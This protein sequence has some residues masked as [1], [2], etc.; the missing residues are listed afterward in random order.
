[1]ATIELVVNAADYT[2]NDTSTPLPA[3]AWTVSGNTLVGSNIEIPTSVYD[4]GPARLVFNTAPTG[5]VFYRDPPA[6][7]QFMQKTDGHLVFVAAITASSAALD[8]AGVYHLVEAAGYS[9]SILTAPAVAISGGLSVAAA[10][11]DSFFS[12][13]AANYP[14]GY[15]LVPWHMPS[16]TPL[17]SFLGVPVTWS[18]EVSV[19]WTDSFFLP[20]PFWANFY[21]QYE[22]Q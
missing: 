16:N 2:D 8:D 22:A 7:S 18:V 13:T 20:P 15:G 1:M 14:I 17:A 6:L 21:G 10:P 4:Y 11:I 9:G 19:Y 5:S 12:G 3:G